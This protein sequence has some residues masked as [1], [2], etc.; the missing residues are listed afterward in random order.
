MIYLITNRITGDRYVGK[1]SRTIEDRWY[2]H[3]KNAEYGQE[4]YLYRAM[5]KYGIDNFTI[6]HLSDGLDEEEILLID[7]L[8]P[9]YNMTS[10]GDGGN[11]S[12]SPNYVNGMLH[13]RSYR[14]ECNPNYGKRGEESPNYG[15]KRTDEQKAKIASSEYLANKRIPVRVHGIDY[16]SVK[17]AADALGRSQRYVRIHDELNEWKY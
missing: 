1:T 11:T 16:D 4:T 10:G 15:K 17:A 12:N 5:R 14:G 9:E 2:Q 13:R 7:Q 3:K 8:H 6:E